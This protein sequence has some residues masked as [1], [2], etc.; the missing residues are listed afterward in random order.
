MIQESFK[1][2]KLVVECVLVLPVS[3]HQQ[4][5]FI[6]KNKIMVYDIIYVDMNL[7]EVKFGIISRSYNDY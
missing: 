5:E 3:L 4:K 6:D 7:K 2:I 1:E